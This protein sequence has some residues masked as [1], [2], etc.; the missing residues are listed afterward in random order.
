MKAAQRVKNQEEAAAINPAKTPDSEQSKWQGSRNR[1][2]VQGPF[3]EDVLMS[4]MCKKR[5]LTK[6]G[7][8]LTG[9]CCSSQGR[10]GGQGG[11]GS[12]IPARREDVVPAPSQVLCW[13]TLL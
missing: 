5:K 11:Q 10:E 7:P 8:E 3:P 12:N 13:D 2:S 1:T 4:H 9:S 6:N